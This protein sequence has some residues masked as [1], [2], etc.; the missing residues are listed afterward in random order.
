MHY[1]VWFGTKYRRRILLGE[2]GAFVQLAFDQIASQ[3]G[4]S[5][6]E[7]AAYVNHAHLL[8]RVADRSALSKAIQL[9]TGGSAYKT[10][11]RYR[12]LK[13]DGRTNHL[14]RQ[15]YGFRPLS[16]SQIKT[17]KQYIRT[18]KDRP[19]AFDAPYVTK[20]TPVSPD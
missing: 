4:L 6:I 17:V 14:W 1:H 19:E 2:V 18:Q 8:I 15:G 3:H 16:R 10:F 20:R 11:R 5:L 7:R 13:L 9:L 12:E